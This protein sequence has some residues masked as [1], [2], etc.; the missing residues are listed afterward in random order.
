MNIR[1]IPLVKTEG[2]MFKAIFTRQK[3]LEEKYNVIEKKNGAIIP[4]LPLDINTFQG[5]QRARDI[6]YRITEE[7]FEA[8]NTLRNKAWKTSMVPC[9][10]D[11]FQEE[12]ADALHFFV[13]LFLELGL[14]SEEVCALYFKKSE[15]NRFRQRSA[16]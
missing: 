14:T 10:V 16:Y 11:H 5:Q 12:L 1:D 15:V 13:Q 6:I 2:D 8:G 7:L 4:T 9:D 3:E